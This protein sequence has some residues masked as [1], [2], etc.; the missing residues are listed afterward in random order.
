MNKQLGACS[1]KGAT[2]EAAWNR[3]SLAYRNYWLS[4]FGSGNFKAK[5]AYKEWEKSLEEYNQSLNAQM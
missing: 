3:L 2:Q 4:D 5:Q 1:K